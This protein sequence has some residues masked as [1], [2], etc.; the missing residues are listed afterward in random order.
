MILKKLTLKNYRR[1]KELNID[2]EE[3]INV[4]IGKNGSGKTTIFEAILYAL[5]GTQMVRT[6]K[7]DI[8]ADFADQDHKCKVCLTFELEDEQYKIER[9]IKGK[10]S[11]TSAYIYSSKRGDNPVAERESGVN[12]FVQKLL[13]MDSTTFKISVFLH[14]KS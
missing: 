11:I 12:E 1:F 4:F 2:F 7:E 5:F 13:S 9:I 10:N 3:N 8:K 14:K 6:A